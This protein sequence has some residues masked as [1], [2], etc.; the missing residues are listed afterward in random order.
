VGPDLDG[1][2][3]GVAMAMATIHDLPTPALLADLEV[4]ERNI[5]R[6]Q[7]RCETLG[8]ALRPNVKTHK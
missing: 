3:V 4:L 7:A 8:V 2:Q 5:A 1:D 6:M